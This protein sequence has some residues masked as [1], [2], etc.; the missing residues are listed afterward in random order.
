MFKK[1]KNTPDTGKRV[2][3]M[4]KLLHDLRASQHAV[5][6]NAEAAQ[7]LAKKITAPE[8]M[9]LRKHLELLQ[10]DLDKF[11]EQLESLSAVVKACE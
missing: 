5:R 2:E 7:V 6:L 9:R 4:R 8:G 3:Q 11:R 10:K 1:S